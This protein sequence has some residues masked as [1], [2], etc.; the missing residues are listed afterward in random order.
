MENRLREKESV[1]NKNV[2]QHWAVLLFAIVLVYKFATLGM[3]PF[4]ADETLYGEM[5]AEEGDHLTFL[6][7]YL[8]YPALWKP[9]LYFAAYSLF[10]PVTSSVFD[11]LEYIYRF[12][13][14]LFGLANAYL[15]YLIARR[16]ENGGTAA[17]TALFF[18]ASFIAIFVE[19][20]LMME[21]FMMFFVLLA[22][23]FYTRKGGGN[24]NFVLAGIFA[25]AAA[26]T[27]SVIAL[28]IPILTLAY[29]LQFD[30]KSLKN[31][32][33]L[34]SLLAVP[35]GLAV[36]WIALSGIGMAQ[37][38]FFIDTGKMLFYDYAAKGL[39]SLVKGI[40]QSV[41]SLLFIAVI[42]AIG[43]R[44][45]WKQNIFFAAWFA[46]IIIPVV[47]SFSMLWYFYYVLPGVCFFA[48]K[49][50]R[51]KGNGIDGFA[52]L[53]LTAYAM[54]YMYYAF[55]SSSYQLSNG[56]LEDGKDIGLM[57]A[58]KENVLFAGIYFPNTVS[59]DYKV[60]A[61]RKVSGAYKDF[62]YVLYDGDVN[63]PNPESLQDFI[64]EYNNT[65]YDAEKG[66]VRMFWTKKIYF[67]ETCIREFDYVVVAPKM[68]YVP[69]GYEIYYEGVNSTI[70][71]RR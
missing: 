17:A 71:V 55:Q 40:S 34:A 23:Y 41:L 10:I 69:D 9:G 61:E 56:L 32:F 66:F 37:E 57:M 11:S 44:N 7:N 33:F 14:L 4:N 53:I 58:G 47:S 45:Y 36:F 39:V 42:S 46:L 27:K 25:L 22:L 29:V 8:G 49:M 2:G 16:F 54:G 65:T 62:G 52:L 70:F 35:A 59:V 15:V 51:Q 21:V 64:S 18:Y 3:V 28:M 6:P 31:P 63:L 26:L 48:A 30:R 60:L 43:L 20:R 38:I 5:I 67:K 68:D 50:L 13:N 1:W 24:M 12:P 19:Q